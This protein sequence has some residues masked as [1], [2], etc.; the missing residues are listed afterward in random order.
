MVITQKEK[1]KSPQVCETCETNVILYQSGN[2]AT[3]P[4]N[5]RESDLSGA[6]VCL[7]A[8]Q[9]VEPVLVGPAGLLQLHATVPLQ[10]QL[11][12]RLLA[13]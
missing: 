7:R 5:P 6:R 12:H 9:A 13:A 4:E 1:Q 3:F 11:G 8:I 10:C 2:H